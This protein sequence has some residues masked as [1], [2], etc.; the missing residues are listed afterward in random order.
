M[1]PNFQVVSVIE[2]TWVNI[3]RSAMRCGFNL[4]QVNLHIRLKIDSDNLDFE[5]LRMIHNDVNHKNDHHIVS[6]L[7]E[8]I[9][10]YPSNQ[11]SGRNV[12]SLNG[13]LWFLNEKYV[14]YVIYVR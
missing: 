7:S 1:M 5:N 4:A 3:N 13:I 14:C 10:K 12:M 8:T 2:L 11:T 9:L 6:K